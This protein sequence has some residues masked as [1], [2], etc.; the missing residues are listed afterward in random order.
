MEKMV[1]ER[2]V[3][4]L[5]NRAA[6]PPQMWGFMRGRSS[7]DNAVVLSRNIAQPMVLKNIVVAVFLD[8]KSAFDSVARYAIC[9]E[10]A[11][12]G[13]KGQMFT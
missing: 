6:Y 9:R 10:M 4:D 7:V 8:V 11:A 2:L 3:W 13:I 12:E 1:L 5:E